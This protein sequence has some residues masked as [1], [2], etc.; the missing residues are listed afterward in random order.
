M[1]QTLKIL[2]GESTVVLFLPVKTVTGFA[3]RYISPICT[4]IFQILILSEFLVVKM[5]HQKI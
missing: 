2:G 3:C 5:E 1:W 4:V